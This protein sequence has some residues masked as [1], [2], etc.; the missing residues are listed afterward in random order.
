MIVLIGGTGFVGA[1]LLERLRQAADVTLVTRDP[2]AAL[3]RFPG[4]RVIGYDELGAQD[5]RGAVII[6][7]AVRNN[8]R[9]GTLE[10][11]RTANVDHLLRTAETTRRAGANRFI[12][13]CSTHALQAE[14]NDYYGLSKSEG[15]R[16][17]VALWPEGARNLYIPALYGE[18]FAGR[19]ASLNRFPGTARRLALLLLRQVK[20]LIS[21]DTL[22]KVLLEFASAAEPAHHSL[23]SERYAADPVP[24]HGLYA[25][26][27][28]AVDLLGAVSVL[29]LAGWAMVLIALYVRFD[30]KGPAIFAQTRVGRQGRTFTCYKFRT[31]SV[32]T[33]QVAT[34]QIQSA[35]VTRAGAFLRRTKLDELPQV[36]NV[37][38][39][40]MSLVGPRPCLPVQHELIARREERGVLQ[41]KPGVTG[42][43]QIND[44]DMSDPDRLA[45]WDDR[46]GVFRTIAGDFKILLRTAIGKGGGDRVSA[47]TA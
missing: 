40:Q 22:L 39:N 37:L 25:S 28:R 2:I 19:L 33:A 13:L 4:V 47:S 41:L 43:A 8:D 5:L 12:N 29:L 30:S 42:L 18:R 20:P 44:I 14:A 26:L 15:A 31:M 3:E 21:I 17:L 1:Q 45:A 35:A 6:H 11:F 9:P 16:R 46:Y 36:V 10:D 7:L 38:L 32:G 34:H 27:K 23:A 24:A